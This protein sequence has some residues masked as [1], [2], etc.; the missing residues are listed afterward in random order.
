MRLFSTLL[1]ISLVAIS[2]S[3]KKSE[4][5]TLKAGMWR[6]TLTLQGQE[7]PFNFEVRKDSSGGY[8]LFLRNANEKL[9]L[10]EVKVSGDSVDI[11]LH[12]FDANIKA[13]IKGDSL[14]GLFIKNYEKDYRVPFRAAFGQHFRFAKPANDQQPVDFSGKYQ[15]VF[16]NDSDTTIAVGIFKQIK[17]SVTGTFLTTTGDYR[18]LEG[19]VVSNE[20]K[21]STFDGNHS[22]IFTAKKT[23]D[24]KLQGE[25]IS[26]KTWKQS[27]TGI[28]NENASLPD[29]ES[30]TVLK[31]GYETITF[32]FPDAN[33]KTVSLADEKYRN[34]VVIIQLFGTW[35]PNCMDE[36]KFLAPWYKQNQSRGVEIIGLAYERKNDFKYASERLKK[37]IQK[38]EVS[39]DFAIAPATNDKEE[40]AK[41]LPMLN[42]VVAFPTTIFIGKDGKVKKIHTGFSGPGTG[43]YY[44]QFIQHFNETVNEL[45]SENSASSKI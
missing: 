1:L 38:F 31:P 34:K 36:T 10:D 33:G 21:L 13:R 37:M 29:A 6:A 23:E 15:V 14:T 39:Y 5:A 32:S 40:A 8:N 44:D 11:P 22:Y 28:K 4:P 24:G 42:K 16:T 12:V 17:D 20:M 3:T 30:L 25:Y 9:L 26:G 19:N 43:I 2:C 18:F 35:C 7:L 41:T 45:L 27:W